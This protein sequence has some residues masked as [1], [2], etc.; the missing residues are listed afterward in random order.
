MRKQYP[1]AFTVVELLVVLAAVGVLMVVMP[2]AF[3]ATQ[4]R[5]HGGNIM[6][7][8][9]NLR[10][11]HAAMATYGTTNKD[12][13][14]GLTSKGDYISTKFQGK[15]HSAM[16]NASNPQNEKNGAG[17]TLSTGANLAMAQLLDEG[18][19]TPQQLVSP[20]E[21][22]TTSHGEAKPLIQMATPIGQPGTPA[23][24]M[25]DMAS[26]IPAGEVKDCHLSFAMLAYGRVG[27]K[28]EWR[29]NQ[30][31]EAIVLGTRL[32]FGN[33]SGAFNSVWTEE[34]SGK[35][36]GTVV[37]GDSSTTNEVFASGHLDVFENLRYGGIPIKSAQ[38]ESPNAVG[39]FGKSTDMGNFDASE[40]TGMIG[41]VQD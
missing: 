28:P 25:G 23:E 11:I 27:L 15:Y 30:N 22:N 4:P 29:S 38:T 40:K 39:V 21:T 13:F 3:Y 36:R 20:G 5:C 2:F 32:I 35:W 10:N 26:D 37:R 16:P 24:P 34:G 8:S 1:R 14:P 18:M 41:S 31:Q 33:Q 6:K 7:E 19:V 12:W 17:C 9:V